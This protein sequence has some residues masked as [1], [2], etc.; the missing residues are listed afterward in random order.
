VLTSQRARQAF[1]LTREPPAV[2]DR[3]GEDING[4]SVLLAR[5]LVEAGVP[6][7]CVHWIG[8]MIGAAFIWDTHGDNF[9]VLRTVLL[10]AF[11][12]CF[13]ALLDDWSN[14]VCSTRRW[15]W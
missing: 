2:R 13:S 12:A 11:D 3:Y 5:R 9:Q 14:A 7:A 8:R 4:Q 1:D 10:P 6:F 15:W